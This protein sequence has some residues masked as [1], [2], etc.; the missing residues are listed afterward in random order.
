[1]C[2]RFVS[3]TPIPALA[4]RFRVKNVVD[5]GIAPSYN[6]APT[7]DIIMVND[8][9]ERQLLPCRWGFLPVWA[10]DISMGN[11]MINARSET[12]ATKPAFRHAFRKQRCLIV[13]DGFYEW[14]SRAGKKYPFYIRLTSKEP[15]G[16]AGLYTIWESPDGSPVCTCTII[17]TEANELI[18]PI[19]NRMP[20]MLQRD[21][22]DF[23]LDPNNQDK[24]G[25]LA[26]L[27]PYPA[28]DMEL[29]PVSQ[30][31]NLPIHDSAEN[32]EPMEISDRKNP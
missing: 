30:R 9:G 17:T 24:D 4:K 19:H 16:F 2:G 25:L 8:T 26:L 12:V 22:E 29:Y 1:M 11:R 7:K 10:K 20:V 18:Q 21:K 27:A 14:E 5:A 28:Q 3:I 23:W 15:F 6:I 32:I 13:A 31:M